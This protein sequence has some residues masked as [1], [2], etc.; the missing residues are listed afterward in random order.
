MILGP[1]PTESC[2]QEY[3]FS[4]ILKMMMSLQG[5]GARLDVHQQNT[6]P[7]LLRRWKLYKKFGKINGTG[8][9]SVK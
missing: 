2:V 5:N 9:S 7:Y 3:S 6:F 4:V 8:K 1:R